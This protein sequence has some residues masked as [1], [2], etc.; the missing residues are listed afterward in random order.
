MSVQLPSCVLLPFAGTPPCITFPGGAKICATWSLNTPP[1]PDELMKQL[2]SQINTA[3]APLQPVFTLM[4]MMAMVVEIAKALPKLDV[5]KIGKLLPDLINLAKT[6]LLML[7]QASIPLMLLGIL[8]MLIMLLNGQIQYL[9]RVN[10]AL[11]GMAAAEEYA[12]TASGVSALAGAILCG[13]QQLEQYLAAMSAGMEPLNS[14]I[15]AVNAL[16]TVTGLGK[17]VIPAIAGA[18]TETLEPTIEVLQGVI[19]VLTTIRRA[20]PV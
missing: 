12:L 18:T 13:R 2:M 15:S 11:G 9:R 16:L 19:D 10:A 3:L 14:M 20:I 8:D 17:F 4:E 6:L 1:M 7:P 5:K